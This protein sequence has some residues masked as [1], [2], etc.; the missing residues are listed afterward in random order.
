MEGLQRMVI[1]AKTD[2]G[3]LKCWVTL[4]TP[5]FSPRSAQPPLFP[6]E[7]THCEQLRARTRY[8]CG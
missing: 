1:A 7:G 3:F 4:L 2:P 5:V 6:F 8:A